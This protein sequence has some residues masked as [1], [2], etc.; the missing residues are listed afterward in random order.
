MK[1]LGVLLLLCFV[2]AVGSILSRNPQP[3]GATAQAAAVTLSQAD[4]VEEAR[5]RS[6]MDDGRRLGLVNSYKWQDGYGTVVVGFGF[7]QASFEDKQSLDQ[8]ARCVMTEGRHDLAGLKY[9]EYLDFRNHKELA[10][11][12]EVTGF[13]VD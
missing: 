9:V 5:C 8:M 3:A 4:P 12:S 10:K 6:V 7:E 11:W 1:M 2:F 13:S